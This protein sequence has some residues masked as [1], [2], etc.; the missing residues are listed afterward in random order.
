MNIAPATPYRAGDCEG[1]GMQTARANID[2]RGTPYA[3]DDE[4]VKSGVGAAGSWNISHNGQVGLERAHT[5]H[6]LICV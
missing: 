1:D 2:L 6:I 5:L 4:F 3:I